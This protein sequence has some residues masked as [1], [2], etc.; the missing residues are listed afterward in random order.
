MRCR[1]TLEWMPSLPPA[2][3]CPGPF[4]WQ[5]TGHPALGF[6]KVGLRLLLGT[7]DSLGL[8]E[9]LDQDTFIK[10]GREGRL[11]D[12]LIKGSLCKMRILQT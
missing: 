6:K 3:G 9:S 5:H 2:Q 1:L 8:S 7:W 10:A 11:Q 12:N 4:S